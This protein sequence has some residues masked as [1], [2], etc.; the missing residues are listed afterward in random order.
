MNNSLSDRKSNVLGNYKNKLNSIDEF[1]IDIIIKTMNLRLRIAVSLA[2]FIFFNLPTKTFSSANITTLEIDS[3]RPE[4]S[5][6][7]RSIKINL[8]YQKKISEEGQIMKIPTAEIYHQNER[9]LIVAGVESFSSMPAKVEIAEIDPSNNLPEVIFESYSGG[10]HCC[11][12]AKILT[13]VEK[14]KTWQVLE[15]GNFDGEG[16]NPSDLDGD[17]VYEYVTYDNRFLYQF[18]SYAGSAAPPQIWA[19]RSAKAIEVTKNPEYQSYLRKELQNFWNE[20]KSSETKGNGFWAG[21]V[22]WKA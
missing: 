8:S 1:T 17:N 14:Q 16:G 13:S 18:D 3:D 15:L 9:V 12:L 7:S 5:I 20:N 2:I 11:T 10:A 21:Y 22:G 6:S 19:I 4:G